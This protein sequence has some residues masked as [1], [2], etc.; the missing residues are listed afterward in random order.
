MGEGA[1]FCMQASSARF[2]PAPPP[3]SQHLH[4]PSQ[5]GL[6]VDLMWAARGYSHGP[7]LRWATQGVGLRGQGLSGAFVDVFAGAFAEGALVVGWGAGGGLGRGMGGDGYGD[8]GYG[9]RRL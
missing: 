3:F 9:E 1:H 5:I 2:K 7:Q 8:T 4:S 6:Q